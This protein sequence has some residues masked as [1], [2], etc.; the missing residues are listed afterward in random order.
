[1]LRR[2]AGRP[3]RSGP[4]TMTQN[5][6]SKPCPICKKKSAVTGSEFYPFCSE[7]CKLIDLGRWLDGKYT[8]PDSDSPPTFDDPDQN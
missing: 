2:F 6:K 7:Q 8:V 3:A 1:M 4:V 5:L